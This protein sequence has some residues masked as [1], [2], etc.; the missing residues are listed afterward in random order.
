MEKIASQNAPSVYVVIPHFITGGM[1]WLVAVILFNLFPEMFMQHYFNNQLLALTH[2]LVFGWICM[3]IFGTLYQLLPVIMEVKLFSEKLALIS[4]FFLTI[5]A[6]LLPIAFWYFWLQTTLYIAAF[7]ILSGVLIFMINVFIT[8]K[9]SKKNTI[10]KYFIQTSILWFLFTVIIGILLA[11]NL[12]HPFLSVPHLELLKLHA[13]AGIA[14]WFIQLIMGVGSKLFP[15]FLVSHQANS[16][17]LKTTYYLMNTGLILVIIFLYVQLATGIIISS[18]LIVSAI[19]NYL[20]F[21]LETYNKRVKRVL[22]TAMKQSMLSFIMLLVALLLLLFILFAKNLIEPYLISFAIIYGG[23]LLIGFISSLIM[24]QT[25]KILPFIVWLK[26]Y[27]KKAGKGKIPYPKDLY[28][29]N[30]VKL[31][32]WFYVIGFIIMLAG[33]LLQNKIVLHT[34]AIGLLLS[35]LIYNLNMMKVILHK[36]AKYE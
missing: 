24:G 14:G 21:L 16:K 34:G 33:I 8:A 5:G 18:L 19:I 17:K 1:F 30:A 3:V 2:L 6:I 29:E 7:F 32:L 20:S 25:F 12:T 22:D 23:V 9:T 15:M 4:L 31:Q 35:A 27:R 36:P 13:H 28:S 11:V 26:V 10:E